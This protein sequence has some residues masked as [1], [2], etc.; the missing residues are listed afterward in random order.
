[1]K[2]QKVYEA[3][4]SKPRLEILKYIHQKPMNV[5]EIST[6]MNIKPITVRHHIR[7]LE[8]A[9]LV[10]SFEK[11][12]GTPG[13]PKIY[14]TIA[15]EPSMVGYPR[16]HYFTLSN[17][18]IGILPSLV[19]KKRASSILKNVGMSMG[20]KVMSEIQSKHNIENWNPK[21][22]ID[23]FIHGYL[24]DAGAEPEITDISKDR[25]EYRVHNCLFLELAVKMPELMC[26]T[27]HDSFHEGVSDALGGNVKIHRLTCQ[28]HGDSYCRHNCEWGTPSKPE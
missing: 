13:R 9:G 16:R 28:G 8:Q 23:Y 18:M 24:E 3:L 10:D 6:L 25:V 21:A 27:L 7:S 11:K 17:F 14:Y 22:F 1:M 12:E 20:K 4:S 26:E 15:K 5:D 19:G 2:E